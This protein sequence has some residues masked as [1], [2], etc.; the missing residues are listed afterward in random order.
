MVTIV[1]YALYDLPR[2]SKKTRKSF[3]G[4]FGY[5]FRVMLVFINDILAAIESITG[6]I[7]VV[8]V[9]LKGKLTDSVQFLLGNY[10]VI[11]LS[12]ASFITTFNGLNIIM[13]WYAAAMITFGIQVGILSQSSKLAL[14]LSKTKRKNIKAYKEID[15]HFNKESLD[16]VDTDE[17]KRKVFNKSKVKYPWL[18]SDWQS[19]AG[20]KTEK[21]WW[22]ILL[23]SILLIFSMTT[24]IYFSYVYFYNEFI[25]PSLSLNNYI[26]VVEE[27]SKI[28]D[29][30]AKKMNE[31]HNVLLGRLEEINRQTRSML[32]LAEN[33]QVDSIISDLQTRIE[34][35]EG[36]V[37]ELQ[38][39]RY[40][41][42]RQKEELDQTEELDQAEQEGA[43][44]E[45]RERMRDIENQIDKKED[46]IDAL[47]NQLESERTDRNTDIGYYERQDLENAL[48]NLEL[49][50]SD[51]IAYI[52]EEKGEN[53]MESTGNDEQRTEG[54]G[55]KIT[56]DFALI[57]NYNMEQTQ[58]S[59]NDG[60]AIS[61]NKKHRESNQTRTYDTS[62][63]KSW[64]TIFNNYVELCQYYEGHKQVGFYYDFA[65][66]LLNVD[67]GSMIESGAG[68]EKQKDTDA[69][70][71][72]TSAV[73]A[74]ESQKEIDNLF[75]GAS[76]KLVQKMLNEL[77][78]IP[79][80][81]QWENMSAAERQAV[82]GL[83]KT[84]A[85][86][87]LYR[88][89]RVSTG[90]VEMMEMAILATHFKWLNVII[91]F[92]AIF[93][94]TLAVIL[95]LTKGIMHYENKLPRY[96]KLLYR[97]FIHNTLTD[98]DKWRVRLLRW[99]G[100]LGLAAG[101]LLYAFYYVSAGYKKEND[102]QV[103]SFICFVVLT[104]C[105]SRMIAG[106][107]EKAHVNEANW[108]QEEVYQGL[109]S[110][111][112]FLNHVE[113]D[114]FQKRVEK[115]SKENEALELKPEDAK[116]VV[117]LLSNEDQDEILRVLKPEARLLF[118]H[119]GVMK[120]SRRTLE[121]YYANQGFSSAKDYIAGWY[122]DIDVAYIEY[123]IVKRYAMGF[124]FSVLKGEG[125]VEY[126]NHDVK[127][128]SETAREQG[129]KTEKGVTGDTGKSNTGSGFYILSE[130]LLRIL[131][132]LVME[133]SSGAEFEDG[134]YFADDL[135]D[136][137]EED[138]M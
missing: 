128:I 56:A 79:M 100:G 68:I 70:G 4:L 8:R 50:Y 101:M 44:A 133:V 20:Q 39:Q 37:R 12:V 26:Y 134:V 5:A 72:R 25:K 38:E 6:F 93:V 18:E 136:A 106:L 29:N 73:T 129:E 105:V 99:A 111:W 59:E 92:L 34:E 75:N 7:D 137:Y 14:Y 30:Y 117:E 2:N 57:V 124:H 60:S 62:T 116:L 32:N 58:D 119:I 94:D 126:I 21:T 63:Y 17:K 13:P 40:A 131:F 16:Q 127:T 122:D 113:G 130:K 123:E 76:T 85:E 49:F 55:D 114:N 121:Y 1:F 15:Y 112:N 48:E 87:T 45:L 90:T 91:L 28:S 46:E 3:V 118:Q 22:K 102:I 61:K 33:H 108:K 115:A 80:I 24:S 86:K 120:L 96:R 88:W 98:A 36:E 107:Y 77:N 89:Y 69:G 10:A 47:E 71:S 104:S 64:L 19:D 83:S 84:E 23:Y 74:E 42:V 35:K 103:I 78:R 82:Q 41:L 9:V 97:M 125:L 11:A 109:K 54:W 135:A 95:T 52:N 132:E 67:I 65:N 66:E 81:L 31:L 51:P 27:I 138:D 110:S 53:P 43:S